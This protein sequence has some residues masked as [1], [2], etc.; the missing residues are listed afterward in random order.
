MGQILNKGLEE[1][2]SILISTTE[3][4][5]IDTEM[6]ELTDNQVWDSHSNFCLVFRIVLCDGAYTRQT[7]L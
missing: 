5:S 1:G 4:P 3:K 6:Q 2:K 7:C